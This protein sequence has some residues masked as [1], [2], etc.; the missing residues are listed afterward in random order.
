VDALPFS[1]KAEMSRSS[2]ESMLF[3]VLTL[4]IA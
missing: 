2:M 1:L 4:R 3:A